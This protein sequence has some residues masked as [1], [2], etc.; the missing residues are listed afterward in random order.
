LKV[1]ELS[2]ALI[3]TRAVGAQTGANMKSDWLRIMQLDRFFAQ[4]NRRSARMGGI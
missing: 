4:E 1:S 2:N 3:D